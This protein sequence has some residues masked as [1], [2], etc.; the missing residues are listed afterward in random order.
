MDALTLFFAPAG[1][2]VIA[3]SHSLLPRLLS[4][5]TVELVMSRR[6]APFA[7]SFLPAYIK[8][9]KVPKRDVMSVYRSL[10]KWHLRLGPST[11]P[12]PWSPAGI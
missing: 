10:A 3:S 8:L 1:L 4:S 12:R 9:K 6:G 5:P 11:L 7:T 2:V